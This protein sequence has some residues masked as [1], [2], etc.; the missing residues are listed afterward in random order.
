L[1]CESTRNFHGFG[2]YN[3]DN[4]QGHGWRRVVTQPVE[5][6][7]GRVLPRCG[8]SACVSVPTTLVPIWSRAGRTH[9][10]VLTIVNTVMQPGHCGQPCQS[11]GCGRSRGSGTA[12]KLRRRRWSAQ[13][14]ADSSSFEESSNWNSTDTEAVVAVVPAQD[15]E[16]GNR[17]GQLK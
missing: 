16:N 14:K 12:G 8:A 6:K 5:N 15:G 9:R 10:I 13:A 1:R 4:W 11:T 7:L 3:Q 17:D 2:L